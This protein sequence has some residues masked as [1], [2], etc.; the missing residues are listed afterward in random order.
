MGVF[1]PRWGFVFH[2][3]HSLSSTQA[4]FDGNFPYG[5]ADKGP[6][7]E[8][9][10]KVGSYQPNAWGLYDMHGNVWEWCADLFLEEYYSISPRHDPPGPERGTHYVLRGGAWSSTE[11]GC[12]SA[13]R[14]M[15]TQHPQEGDTGFRVACAIAPP[16]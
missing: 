8:R 3:G 1:L 9:T 7:L 13:H 16:G 6:F 15:S 5:G 12:R 10:C 2:Y 4:N 11:V 14:G